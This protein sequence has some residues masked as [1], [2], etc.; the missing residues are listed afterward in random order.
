M[1]PLYYLLPI[2]GFIIAIAGTMM[3]GGGGFFFF[4]LLTL[5]FG[6][7]AH[8]AVGTSL[9]A[10]LPICL[11][12]TIAHYRKG[13]VNLRIAGMFG[14]AG[15]IGTLLGSYLT[16]LMSNKQLRF[17]FGIYSLLIAIHIIYQAFVDKKHGQKAN[18]QPTINIKNISIST[19][20]GLSAGTITGAFGTSGTAPILTGL[21]NLRLP[22]KLVIGTSLMIV[23]INCS[24]ATS[25][26]IALKSFDTRVILLITA[27]TIP[28]AIL[29]PKW[30]TQFKTT[31]TKISIKVIYALVIS[32]IGILMII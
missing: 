23:L 30:L 24:I 1:N 21:F 22:I 6:L 5:L 4:P 2:I 16:V 15:M 20:W 27:G 8:S 12:G 14:I 19:F 17:A 32:T 7:D 28:G 10:T 25:S 26:H 3:G 13:N 9:I 31:E 29:G 18:D 11:V